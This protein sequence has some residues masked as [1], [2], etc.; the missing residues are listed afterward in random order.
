MIKMLSLRHVHPSRR[1]PVQFLVFR[2]WPELSFSRYWSLERPTRPQASRPGERF[3]NTEN[4]LQPNGPERSQAEREI[5]LEEWIAS[6]QSCCGVEP[7]GWEQAQQGPD[8]ATDEA[9]I[10]HKAIELPRA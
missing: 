2:W 4:T 5:T 3:M 7:E 8:A 10:G 6:C 1:Q 9:Q